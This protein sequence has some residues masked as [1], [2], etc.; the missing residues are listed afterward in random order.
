MKALIAKKYGGPEILELKDQPIPVP[1]PDELLVKVKATTV[2][3]TDCG[4]LMGTPLMIR[5]LYGLSKP[6]KE[7][8][9]TD[10]A[11]IVEAVGKNVL[12]W[13]EGD[14]VFGFNDMGVKSHAEYLCI[15]EK[16]SIARLPENISFEQGAASLEG[17]HYALNFLK[18]K[19]FRKKLIFSDKRY[20]KVTTEKVK[21]SIPLPKIETII[22]PRNLKITKNV[23]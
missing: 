14:R 19:N 21:I 3:R 9:G 6:K 16:Q 22:P 2:N 13:K 12:D 7:I 8:P 23:F 18:I 15:S 10:F 11:G 20:L 17:S 4:I 5:M 1:K